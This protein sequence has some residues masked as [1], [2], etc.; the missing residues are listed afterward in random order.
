MRVGEASGTLGV[1]LTYLAEEMEKSKDLRGKVRSA[2]IYPVIILIAT[3]G[4]TGLLVF[5]VFP[6]VLPVFT[7]LKIDLPPTTRA[8]IAGFNFISSYGVYLLA[9]MIVI[10]IGFRLLLFNKKFKYFVDR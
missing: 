4:I 5:F 8:V 7:S 10:P 2:L 6:K 1:N 3:L 9:A